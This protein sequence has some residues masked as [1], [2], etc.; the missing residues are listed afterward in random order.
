MS[1]HLPPVP[2]AASGAPDAPVGQLNLKQVARRLGAHYMTVYRY[3]RQG[4]LE[5]TR[6][7]TTWLVAEEELGRFLAGQGPGAAGGGPTRPARPAHAP[8]AAG[9]GSRVDWAERL[10]RGL[11]A[12][13]E[14]MSWRTVQAAM[15]SGH[16]PA[17]CY[18]DMLTAALTSVGARGQA[19]EIAVADQYLAT[20]VASRVVARLGATCR[21][22]G[23]SRGTV[24][25]GAPLGELHALPVSIAADLVRLV[26]FTVLE[27]GCN[28]PPEAF[29][30]AALRAPRLVAVGIG[31]TSPD[32]LGPVQ[33]TVRAVRE[34]GADVPV[35]VGG[36]AALTAAGS[37]LS[38]V[39]AWA[40]DGPAAVALI[41][42]FAAGRRA[43]KARP[44][45]AL[46]AQAA[47]TLD[48]GS[49]TVGPAAS[50]AP[51]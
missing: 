32:R 41:E 16:S 49:A 5:A 7:G 27:L 40:A 29:A 14:A 6:A 46:A 50:P 20:A 26:G 36:Q 38:G 8:G 51:L 42:G 39:T 4:R 44:G 47:V 35:V 48:D 25:F 43:A 30:V 19:G 24:V 21:R 33:E 34:V 22:P 23:R 28:V 2:S 13:D 3:V 45:R 17:F 37:T 9:R 31:I 12:G 11:L 1:G 18:V 15:A 10:A